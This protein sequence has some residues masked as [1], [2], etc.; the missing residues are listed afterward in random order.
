MDWVSY[1][2]SFQPS[3]SELST[4]ANRVSSGGIRPGLQTLL[5]LCFIPEVFPWDQL[6]RSSLSHLYGNTL[7]LKCY[8]FCRLR[9][10]MSGWMWMDFVEGVSLSRGPVSLWFVSLK[11][12]SQTQR[13]YYQS[14]PKWW[15]IGIIMANNLKLLMVQIRCGVIM[16]VGVSVMAKTFSFTKLMSKETAVQFVFMWLCMYLFLFLFNF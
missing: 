3:D 15:P 6:R 11:G 8:L 5:P 4:V 14:S 2:D 16:K 1:L 7:L 12:V 10:K 13:H 9:L